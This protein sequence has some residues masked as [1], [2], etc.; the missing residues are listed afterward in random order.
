MTRAAGARGVVLIGA[1][2]SG[3]TSVGRALA[4]ALG[5]E[6]V[7]ID[8]R[9]ER[10]AGRTIAEIFAGEGEGGFRALETRAIG[11]IAGDGCGPR[12]VSA[13]GGAVLR[14]ENRRALRGVG[15]CVWL[16]ATVET[17]LRR[18]GSDPGGASRRPA[19]SRAPAGVEMEAVLRA[20]EPLYREMA[21]VIIDTE[22]LTPEDVVREVTAAL[23]LR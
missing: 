16:T 1:R 2:G 5:W 15:P 7:D 19:L 17:L 12:V 22:R 8:E 13:G 9:I 20:R 10:R 6:F 14:V 11:E 18:V 21:D 23:S 4:S 3:K